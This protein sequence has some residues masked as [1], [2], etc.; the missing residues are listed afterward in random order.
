LGFAANWG[1]QFI[2]SLFHSK[3]VVALGQRRLRHVHEIMKSQVKE[4]L[5]TMHEFSSFNQAQAIAD[6][7]ARATE[8][9]MYVVYE[10]HEFYV[11]TE[12]DLSTFFA[13]LSDNQVRYCTADTSPRDT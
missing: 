1:L 9:T 3:F 7:Y 5:M 11:A 2:G 12:E 10:A 8:R 6:K 13:G 4:H